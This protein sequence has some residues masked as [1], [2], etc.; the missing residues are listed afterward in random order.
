[1]KR[2]TASQAPR[3]ITVRGKRVVPDA[4]L[5]RLYGV[6]TSRFNEAVKRNAAKFP[7]DFRFQLNAT[8]AAALTSQSAISKTARCGRRSKP[9]VFT[10]HGSL[11]AATVLNSRRAVQMSV[12]VVRAF[13]QMREELAA[14]ATILKRLAEIDRNLLQHDSA[15]R[16]LWSKLQP[17]LQAPPRTGAEVDGVSHAP[18]EAM[19]PA[20]SRLARTRASFSGP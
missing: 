19:T 11:M 3:I 20:F 6:P 10:E 7:K 1:M 8:E 4:E 17:L 15:L 2:A 5:A 16:T 14:N 18:A 9:W 13:V 12:Y